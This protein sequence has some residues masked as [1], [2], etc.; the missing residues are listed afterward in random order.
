M[1]KTRNT[2]E[3]E[4]KISKIV[5]GTQKRMPVIKE[6]GTPSV[7]KE[8]EKGKPLDR[9]KHLEEENVKLMNMVQDLQQQLH[10]MKEKL[11]EISKPGS[12]SVQYEE[13]EE[14]SSDEEEGQAS[15]QWI[16]VNNTKRKVVKKKEQS[17]TT[18]SEV[19]VKKVP[20]VI[21][22]GENMKDIR[23]M[24]NQT[25]MPENKYFLVKVGDKKYQARATDEE[26]RDIIVDLLKKNKVNHYTYANKGSSMYMTVL[27]GLDK[28]EDLA[29][30]EKEIEKQC[31]ENI[32]HSVKQVHKKGKKLPVYLV[33]IKNSESV[34]KVTSIRYLYHS[35]VKWERFTKKDIVQ[36]YNCQRLGHIAKYCNMQYRCVKCQGMHDPK[37]C[38]ISEKCKKEELECVNCKEKG[39]PASYKGCPVY[40]TAIANRD[41]RPDAK[42]Y[43]E[44][45]KQK[46]KKTEEQNKQP[47]SH[48]KA[49][50]ENSKKIQDLDEKITQ[51]GKQVESINKLLT[52]ILKQ[53]NKND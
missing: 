12:S 2:P 16:D 33:L 29:D 30:L 21:F 38:N 22:F 6:K 19:S 34:Q 24:F 49:E 53:T 32:V 37:K 11:D 20:P 45:K 26:T 23:A 10:R 35:K 18:K 40:Q 48:K 14:S 3:K 42:I 15:T 44:A 4:A 41:K 17:T 47:A 52:E 36:C 46:T 39:H 27:K 43:A 25:K 9:Q 7:T 5:A 50:N 1:V 51:I 31:G 28:D 8:V 13:S